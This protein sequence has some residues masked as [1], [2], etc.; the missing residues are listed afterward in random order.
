MD[1]I[2]NQ[3]YIQNLCEELKQSMSELKAQMNIMENVADNAINAMN[4]VPSDVMDSSIESEANALK[5]RI[6]D[7]DIEAFER[8]IETCEMR[9]TQLIP[10]ADAEY[11][12]QIDELMCT[13]KNIREAAAEVREFLKNTP[14]TMSNSDFATA[15]EVMHTK[16]SSSLEGADARMDKILG[17]IKGAEKISAV[18]SRDPVNLSTGNFIY[19]HTDLEIKGVVP[20]RFSRFYNAVNHRKGALGRDWNHNYEVRLVME[21]KE[22]VLIRED[23]KEERFIK[24]STGGYV[25]VYHSNG[26]LSET[27]EGYIYETKE[28]AKYYFDKD[29]C[30][31]RQDNG[32]GTVIVL[33]YEDVCGTESDCKTDTMPKRLTKVERT[34]GEAFYLRYNESGHLAFVTD[35]AGRQITYAMEGELLTG[36]T[37]PVGHRMRYEYTSDGK[38]KGVINPRGI[39]TVENEFDSQM[40]TTLQKFPDGGQMSYAYDDEK[41]EVEL[42][43]RN[44]SKVTYVHDKQ[45]RDIRHI[46]ADGEERFEY[47]KFNQKTLVVD[48]LGN[49]T[50]FGYDS[51]GNLTRII[52]AL[53]VKTEIQYNEFNKPVRVAVNGVEKIRNRYDEEGKLVESRD[54]LGNVFRLEYEGENKPNKLIQPDGSELRV[55]YDVRGNITSM[56]DANGGIS[57]FSYDSLNQVIETIDANGNVTKYEYDTNGNI[58]KIINSVGDVRLYKYNEENKVV[59]FTDFNGS[60]IGREYNAL[61]KLSKV[62]DQMGRET[63]FTYDSMWNLARI[64]LPDGSKTTYMYN[65]QNLLGRIRNMNGNVLRYSYDAV[66]NCIEAEDE[67]GNKTHLSYDALRR[68]TQVIGPDGTKI[69]YEYNS[70]GKVTKIADSMNHYVGMKYNAG[71]QL[72]MEINQD[73]E[74]R[75][76]TYTELGKIK[77]IQSETGLK[78]H[79]I[80]G[81]GGQLKEIVFPDGNKEVYAYDANGNIKEHM[82]KRGYRVNYEYNS[83][84][85][86]IAVSGEDGAKKNYI[87]DGVGNVTGIIDGMGN[88][89]T[90]EY[91][92][93]GKLTKVIDACGNQTEYQY[94]MRDQLIGVYQY[95]DFETKSDSENKN[96][97]ITRYER[98]L[99]GQ[100]TKVIDPIGQ[101]ETY[102]YNKKGQLIEKIDKEGYLT[103]YG[104]TVKG[105]LNH[106]QYEDGREVKLGYNILRQ[107]QE[108]DDWLGITKIE[109]DRHGNATRII[110]PNGDEISYTY[111]STGQR[112]SVIYPDKTKIEYKY[113]QYSRLTALLHDG[114]AVTYE[115]D[116]FGQLSKKKYP[117]GVETIYNFSPKGQVEKLLHIDEEGII[118]QYIYEYDILGNKTGIKKCRREQESEN[119][120]YKYNYDALGRLERII[121]DGTVLRSYTYDAF[122]NRTA[123]IEGSETTCYSYNA[124]NQLTLKKNNSKETVYQYDHRGNLSNIL[125]NGILKEEYL[126]GANNRLEQATNFRGEA[127]RYIY[128]GLGHRVSKEEGNQ[129]GFLIEAF[130]IGE[131]PVKKIERGNF[132][133]T[134]RIDYVLDLTKGYNNLLQK[135]E[136]GYTQSYFWDGK[137]VGMLDEEKMSSQYYMQDELGSVL[138]LVDDTGALKECYGYDEFGRDLYENQGM[139]QPFGYTGYQYDIVTGTYYAQAREYRTGEGRFDGRDLFAGATN[140]PITMNRY[141]YCFNNSMAL[142]DLNGAWPSW[143]DIGEG[144]KNL[145]TN[146]VNKLT[147]LGNEAWEAAKDFGEDICNSAIDF[148]NNLAKEAQDIAASIGE[149]YNEFIVYAGERLDKAG[150][151][152]SEGADQLGQWIE[153][154][155]NTVK[156]VAVSEWNKAQTAVINGWNSAKNAAIKG[157]N[158]ITTAISDFV[159]NKI[160]GVDTILYLTDDGNGT[161]YKVVS[162]SGGNIFVISKN[163]EGIFAGWSI[164]ASITIGDY[165]FSSSLYGKNIDPTTWVYNECLSRKLE[166]GIK[167][168]FG[169]YMDSKGLG[170]QY[171]NSGTTGNFPFSLPGGVVIEDAASISWSLNTK[172]HYIDWTQLFEVATVAAA[173][174]AFVFVLGN[175]LVGGFGDDILLGPLGG[176][177]ASKLPWLYELI[178]GLIPSLQSCT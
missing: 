17:N 12:E 88:K 119:G 133:P 79:Y 164:N 66:G 86:V 163:A 100:V 110:A 87:Y 40:R 161:T 25:S 14:L 107:L 7:I 159:S 1:R 158:G 55:T 130:E 35:H 21:D 173:A 58:I 72:I 101:I 60:T 156:S 62:I 33:Y 69:F 4:Q 28:Q 126:Y 150:T 54:A 42:T 134:N 175:D 167:F 49:K 115:Y 30:C 99:M 76:Y 46:Y 32:E 112:E 91:S 135:K 174:V 31:L 15:Y 106:I 152:I 52:N 154:S 127:A 50:Q 48:K 171:G 170:V 78:I 168:T 59:Q 147:Q 160:V 47:N 132:N 142:V 149:Y 177:I 39:R 153:N 24:A 29:G 9:A 125:E 118:D 143:S 93:T 11:R 23:G 124:L 113:D 96:C 121:K 94:D 20:F 84:N 141:T 64:V 120:V 2:F 148:G 56:I 45:Y 102:G 74:S 51:K 65:E 70:E 81:L 19:D 13:I 157:W 3:N 104:Y 136:R 90:Y 26:A 178:S 95:G 41:R 162:H 73:G 82:D 144:L 108:V 43:E 103:R 6:A 5:N 37:T 122:G 129:N 22:L 83:L 114:K 140:I 71:G 123:L 176:Y 16:C 34:T 116:N 18:F 63:I 137:V 57:K 77:S 111:T 105:D 44:G 61:N 10:D 131:D 85:Q 172:I 165:T 98:N 36:V 151:A 8:K 138:R 117:N 155:W 166:N 128:N 53:G 146:A 89:T 92:L 68:L 67:D 38:L 139:T 97:Q 27:E 145:G 109:T 80:Y 169:R 75:S